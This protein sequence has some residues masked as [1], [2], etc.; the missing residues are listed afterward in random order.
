MAN[1]TSWRGPEWEEEPQ[2]QRM[3]PPI[4]HSEGITFFYVKASQM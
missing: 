1:V 3:A 2:E 4:F